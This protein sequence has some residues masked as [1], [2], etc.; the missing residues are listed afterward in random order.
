MN[1]QIELANTIEHDVENKYLLLTPG[2]LSTS[3][4]V[5]RVMQRDWCTW[6][7]EYNALV[8]EIRSRLVALATAKPEQYSAVLMQGSGSFSVEAVLGSA[9][10]KD[11][12]ILIINNGAYGARMVQMARCLKIDVVEL[13]YPEMQIPQ[14]ADIEKALEDDNI[15]HVSCVHCE[16]TTGLLNPIQAIDVLL[17]PKTKCGLS[18]R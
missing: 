6:D 2:P 17:K 15:T 9:I 12:K 14:L 11:G 4:S 16:T 18:M 5:R 13:R 3:K 1:A 8:Q 10:P 7:K